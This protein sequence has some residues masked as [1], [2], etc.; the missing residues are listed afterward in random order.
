MTERDRPIRRLIPQRERESALARLIAEGKA[1]RAEGSLD[2]LPRL[3][4]PIDDELSR[5]LEGESQDRE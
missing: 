1:T 2:D 3:G 5:A 4:G